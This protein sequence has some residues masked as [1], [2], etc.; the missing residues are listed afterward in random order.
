MMEVIHYSTRTPQEVFENLKLNYGMSDFK[1]GWYKDI[2]SD[3]NKYGVQKTI[4]EYDVQHYLA[5]NFE[6][7]HTNKN[8]YYLVLN[9]IAYDYDEEKMKHKIQFRW[10]TDYSHY[11]IFWNEMTKHNVPIKCWLEYCNLKVD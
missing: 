9:V 10:Q 11:S 6:I 3:M 2:Y 8:E 4:V 5:I 7:I 1:A